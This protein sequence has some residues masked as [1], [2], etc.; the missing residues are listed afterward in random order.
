MG[1][2]VLW[3]STL[4]ARQLNL[5]N[6]TDARIQHI[7]IANPK[8]A[9]YGKRAEE[10]LRATGMWPKVESRLVYGEN[11]SQA[12]Q[13]ALTGTAQVGLVALSLALT[14]E[15]KGKGNYTL[16]P[17]HLHQPLA[18]GYVILKKGAHRPLVRQFGDYLL[19][20]SA[21]AIFGKYGFSSPS[22]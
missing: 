11:I 3:S 17:E 22:K 1:H 10:A 12:A 9:P 4:E 20:P 2:L 18:Q 13:F 8:L 6:L 14:P 5:Q 15:M 7:A 19:T 21:Q 16:V